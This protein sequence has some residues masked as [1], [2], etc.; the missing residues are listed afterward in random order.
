M[1]RKPAKIF[2]VLVFKYKNEA[3]VLG[4]IDVLELICT[5][6]RNHIVTFRRW[7]ILKFVE[8]SAQI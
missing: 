4:I 6:L 1:V 2:Y 3:K 8:K 5:L 7:N